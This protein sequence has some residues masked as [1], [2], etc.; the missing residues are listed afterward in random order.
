MH[1][2]KKGTGYGA[3][4]KKL[5][6]WLNKEILCLQTAKIVFPL[7]DKMGIAEKGQCVG[8]LYSPE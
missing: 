3:S 7:S 1:A 6:K 5:F 2:N 4:I 8:P